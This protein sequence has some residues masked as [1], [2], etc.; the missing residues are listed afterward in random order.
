MKTD[1]IQ[2]F[3]SGSVNVESRRVDNDQ[4]HYVIRI[5][6]GV[7]VTFT[8]VKLPLTFVL[9]R[10]YILHYYENY[11]GSNYWKK[12]VPS[13]IAEALRTISTTHLVGEVYLDTFK[14]LIVSGQGRLNI[15]HMVREV[16]K[17]IDMGTEDF[18]VRVQRFELSTDSKFQV[19]QT[20]SAVF[21]FGED[22]FRPTK[23][24]TFTRVVPQGAYPFN[25]QELAQAM[26]AE[27]NLVIRDI[28]G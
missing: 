15:P 16:A 8:S 5:D 22:H 11:G 27:V 23:T 3:N 19:I 17:L 4:L 25:Y 24:V 1:Y 14:R 13:A 2:V 18:T 28:N 20:L 10:A 7:Q 26:R 6:G 21:D 12:A 9:E